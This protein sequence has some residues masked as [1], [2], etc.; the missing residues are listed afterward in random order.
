MPLTNALQTT[1]RLKLTVFYLSE[2]AYRRVSNGHDT[3]SLVE[4]QKLLLRARWI[5]LNFIKHRLD[6][7]VAQQISQELQAKV[8]D[9]D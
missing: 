3:L 6:P 9:A 1:I 7:S 5:E 4:P 8:A 2:A